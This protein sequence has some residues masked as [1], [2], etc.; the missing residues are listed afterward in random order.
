MI[1]GIK[2][3]IYDAITNVNIPVC[4]I[5]I[6]TKDLVFANNVFK[7]NL[8]FEITDTATAPTNFY[9][10]L[11]PKNREVFD[12]YLAQILITGFETIELRYLHKYGQTIAVTCNAYIDKGD[13]NTPDLLFIF[14]S[15]NH[16]TTKSN[17]L[18]KEKVYESF[19]IL[20]IIRDAYCCLDN[21]G[22]FIFVNQAFES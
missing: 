17:I 6:D 9:T 15:N 3:K 19:A 20:E 2:R 7:S 1:E 21:N 5:N 16:T 13:N 22:D 12:T 8:G 4:C 14:G 18:Q 11:H 10:Y